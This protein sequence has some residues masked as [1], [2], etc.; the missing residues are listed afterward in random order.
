M[1]QVG[2]GII[3][4]L[5][6]QPSGVARRAKY[7][8]KAEA[9]SGCGEESRQAVAIRA[10]QSLRALDLLHGVLLYALANGISGTVPFLMLLR[11]GFLYTRP[12]VQSS[13]VRRR[14]RVQA[15]GQQ[16]SLRRRP[17]SLEVAAGERR[18]LA[19]EQR[20]ALRRSA[21]TTSTSWPGSTPIRWSS[22][23]RRGQGSRRHK[24]Q[25]RTRSSTTTTAPR[26]RRRITWGPPARS[27]AS[28]CSTTSR[29]RP[30]AGR[31][32]A[33]HRV[34]GPRLRHRNGRRAAAPRLR[35]ARCCA[36]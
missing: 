8:S 36:D 20:L 33:V 31:L 12:A 34:P 29:A 35:H 24:A 6:R 10:A 3:G 27:P 7:T 15:G 4:A 21:A 26:P 30:T 28:T 9:T 13:S 17:A 2:Q 1:Q 14:P 25:M 16:G 22:P 19:E 5:L 11:V 23:P 32:C 18:H